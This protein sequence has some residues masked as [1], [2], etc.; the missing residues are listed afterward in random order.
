LLIKFCCF[1]FVTPFVANITEGSVLI[2]ASV[3]ATINGS[4]DP[5][6]KVSELSRENNKSSL[7]SSRILASFI[8]SDDGRDCL[9]NVESGQKRILFENSE[10]LLFN[11]CWML[12]HILDKRSPLVRPDIKEKMIESSDGTIYWP[13][14]LTVEDGSQNLHCCEG[15]SNSLSFFKHMVVSIKALSEA[16]GQSVFSN[17]VFSFG[18]ILVGY[19][20][21]DMS[22]LEKSSK[23]KKL[24]FTLI[25][26]VIRT[27]EVDDNFDV[28]E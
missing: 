7:K 17:K 10:N 24:D 5:S 20:H 8:K 19:E 6:N 14:E 27:C 2:E 9:N 25:N 13:C 26:D 22:Y 23:T 12:K 1:Q 18:Q 3:I 16:S 28:N 21:V 15:I 4:E 11:K